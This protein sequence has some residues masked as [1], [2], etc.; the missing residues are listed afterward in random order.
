MALFGDSVSVPRATY[1][2][3]VQQLLSEQADLRAERERY[4]RLLTQTM[5]IKRHEHAMMPAG[6][7]PA[8]LDPMGQL[9]RQTQ[10]A[11]EEVG[12]DPELRLYLRNFALREYMISTETDA[13]I[14]DK[15]VA[16]RI[17]DGDTD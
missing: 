8:A 15:I 10:A 1:D 4:D 6:F 11:I 14:K 3:L 9:G 2:L 13:D 12:R 5:E 17:L 7:G 16:Q